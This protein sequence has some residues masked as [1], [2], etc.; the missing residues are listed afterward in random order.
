MEKMDGWKQ[1][2]HDQKL[3]FAAFLKEKG[4]YLVLFTCLALVGVAAAFAFVGGESANPEPTPEQPASNSGDET[5]GSANRPSPVPSPSPAPSASPIPDFTPAPKP[6][7]TP[8][9]TTQKAPAPVDGEI[10]WAF[11]IDE[12]T[13]SRTLNQWMTHPGIDIA[14]KQDTQVRAVL[15]GK[16]KSVTLDGALGVM[17]TIEHTNGQTSVYANLKKD[18]PVKEGQKVNARD[19]IGFI[20]DTAVSECGDKSHLHF[21][22]HV[23]GKPK[24]PVNYVLIP[25]V[26]TEG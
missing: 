23:N 9:Q 19:V 5:I 13:Y 25:K 11:A 4:L 2:F 8:K 10:I 15:G 18:P 22:F 16:V 12:L 7:T 14:A 21:E 3:R 6:D 20:G 1:K 24:N 17:I 26:S